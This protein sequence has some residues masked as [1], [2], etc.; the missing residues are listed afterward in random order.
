MIGEGNA[1]VCRTRDVVAG[2]Q[3]GFGRE[4]GL[5]DLVGCMIWLYG[6]EGMK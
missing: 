4:G 3:A 6:N 5:F 2:F 1:N